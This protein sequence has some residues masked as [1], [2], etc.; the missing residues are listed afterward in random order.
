MSEPAHFLERGPDAFIR[1]QVAGDNVFGMRWGMRGPLAVE[2]EFHKLLPDAIDK[3]CADKPAASR[4]DNG[5]LHISDHSCEELENRHARNV[6]IYHYPLA[7]DPLDRDGSGSDC[8]CPRTSPPSNS[9]A[10][11]ITRFFTMYWPS[12]VRFQGWFL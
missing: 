3:R 7:R 11:R 10:P 1:A 2:A 8:L 9:A 6:S 5:I 4:N 12:R